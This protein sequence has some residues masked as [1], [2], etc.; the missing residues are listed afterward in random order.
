MTKAFGETQHLRVFISYSRRDLGDADALVVALEEHGFEVA[1]DRRDLPYGEEWQKELADFIRGS[2]TV[3]WLVSPDSA[4]SKWCNWELGEVGRLNKRLVPVRIRQIDPATL[5]EALG[6]I[7]LLPAEDVFNLDRHLPALVETLNIDRAWLR[8]GTRLADRAR[9]WLAKGRNS[10]LLLRG[11]ALQ[12]AESWTSHQ[13]KDAPLP[14]SEVLDLILTSRRGATRRQRWTVG[15]SLGAA[16][17]G[18]GLAATAFLFQRLAEGQRQVAEVQRTIAERNEKQAEEQRDQA[19]VTQSRFL[20]DLAQQRL[21]DG[22]H[23]TGILLALA[24]LPDARAGID[25]PYRPEPESALKW[26]WQGL[27]ERALLVGHEKPLWSAVFSPDGKRIVTASEDNTARIWDA[28]TGKQIVILNG[29]TDHVHSAVFSPD[30]LRVATASGDATARLWDADTGKQMGL[31]KGH[32]GPLLSV[33]FRADGRRVVTTAED[34]TARI[35]DATTGS[36]LALLKGHSDYVHSAAFSPDGH[37]IV[38]ASEDATVRLWD[39]E[40]G[41]EILAMTNHDRPV[42]SAA[43]VRMGGELLPPQKARPR[44]SPTRR[45]GTRSHFSKATLTR[46]I[47]L[48]SAPTA[49]GS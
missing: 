35:W 18:L 14:P 23:G 10:G 25:R 12:D 31:L 21:R 4:A 45:M 22:D 27:A 6:K 9:Q 33:V 5:P 42:W 15:L 44:C 43:L 41:G 46:S 49:A 24:A 2:D 29:H 48:P 34:H 17:V 11:V 47:A 7:H 3:V 1:I 40:T 16:V 39:A 36:Q 26:A 20:A 13:P 32:E 28:A 8:E 38:T 30:G 19:L 37:R